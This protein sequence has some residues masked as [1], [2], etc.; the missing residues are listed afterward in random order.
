MASLYKSNTNNN[1]NQRA[2]PYALM[3]LLAFGAAILGVMV[4]HKLREKRIF[5]LL[6]KEKVLTVTSK[7]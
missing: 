4:L 3:L 2:K 6:V 1:N 7:D 5:T